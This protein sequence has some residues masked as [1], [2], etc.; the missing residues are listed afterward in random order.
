VFVGLSLE[1][2]LSE[3]EYLQREMK[4]TWT[5]SSQSDLLSTINYGHSIGKRTLMIVSQPDIAFDVVDKAPAQSLVLLVLSDEGYS[6]KTYDL[7][8]RHS[9]YAVMRNYSVTQQKNN[10]YVRTAMSVLSNHLKN[11]DNFLLAIKEVAHLIISS[12]RIKTLMSKW[13]RLRKPLSIL[14]LGYTNKFAISYTSFEG[15][16]NKGTLLRNR[17]DRDATRNIS[18]SFSGT[19]G[20]LQRRST[21]QFLTRLPNSRINVT[22]NDWNGHQKSGTDIE[23]CDTLLSSFYCAALPG[24]ISNESFRYYEALICGALPVR[25]HVSISQGALDPTID[26]E[27]AAAIKIQ[28]FDA[29]ISR[30]EATRIE[31]L[32]SLVTKFD[33][34]LER[35]INFLKTA[36][37][38]VVG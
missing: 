38:S 16:S 25:F 33:H 21:I 14:P 20:S 18:I 34:E 10:L 8:R 13:Q 9:V 2:P 11:S 28:D 19:P 26:K 37:V 32:K 30:P 4:I 5:R 1:E 35:N 23:Y 27:T 36:Q 6:E 3:S 22:T 7:A 29:L 12:I 24:Y 15:T 17:I 31:E